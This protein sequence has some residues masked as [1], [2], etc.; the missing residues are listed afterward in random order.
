MLAIGFDIRY[1]PQVAN[2][3]PLTEPMLNN[4]HC[5]IWQ[6]QEGGEAVEGN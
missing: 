5:T 1:V 4:R 3:E 6:R 2:K